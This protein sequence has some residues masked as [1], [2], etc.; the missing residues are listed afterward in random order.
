MWWEPIKQAERAA[1]RPNQSD[2]PRLKWEYQCADCTEWHKGSEVQVDHVN[3]CGTL[4]SLE[5]IPAFIERLL[6]EDPNDYQVLCK[7]CHQKKTNAER[8]ARTMQKEVASVA[9]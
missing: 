4:L 3:P 5:D 8:E 1:R 2:N 9:A 6:S 7:Q